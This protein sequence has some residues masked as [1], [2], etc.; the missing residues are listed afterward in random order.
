MVENGIKNGV[1]CLKLILIFVIL[2]S[3]DKQINYLGYILKL[4]LL[5][6][7]HYKKLKLVE[8]KV[9]FLFPLLLSFDLFILLRTNVIKII[10]K[11]IWFNS[12]IKGK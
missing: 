12:L 11:I 8:R 7:E 3:I 4:Q 6:P 10:G 5:L 2:I 1:E 9:L